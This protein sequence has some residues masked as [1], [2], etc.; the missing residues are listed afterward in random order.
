MNIGVVTSVWGGYDQFLP[1]WLASVEAQTAPPDIVTILDAGVRDPAAVR[2]LAGA[3]S[4]PVQVVEESCTGM[5]AARNA[6]VAATYTEWVMHLDA[7]DTLLPDA[8]ADCRKVQDV[9]DVVCIGAVRGDQITVFHDVPRR[10]FLRGRLGSFSPSPYRRSLWEQRPY[11]TVNDFVE[12]ALWVGFAHL[13]ARFVGTGRPGFIYRQHPESHS[14]TVEQADKHAARQQLSRLCR[15][16]DNEGDD[17][18]RSST[19]TS[20][21][22]S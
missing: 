1:D 4:L 17:A 8:L 13:G 16:W 15:R 6:A 5:G 20:P 3:S 21:S 18:W 9:A 14:R 11:V 12:S 22:Q 19:G 2:R 10:W 7:D